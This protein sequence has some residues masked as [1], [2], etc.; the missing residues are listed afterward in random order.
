M[1]WLWTWCGKSFGYRIGDNLWTYDGK[2]AGRFIGNEIYGR[3]GQYL[4]ELLSGK[5]LLS[6]LRKVNQ[7]A[8]AFVPQERRA[9]QPKLA[10]AADYTMLGTF[11]EFPS[12]DSF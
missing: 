4:G 11:Q 6:D 10:H 1:E 7:R 8:S 12:P 3:N 2:H 5:R 9:P